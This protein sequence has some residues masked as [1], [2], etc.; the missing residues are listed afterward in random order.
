MTDK[1]YKAQCWLNRNYNEYKK[2]EAERRVLATIEDRLFRGTASYYN[3]GIQ[4]NADASNKRREDTLI[5]YTEQRATLERAVRQLAKK[6]EM[7]RAVIDQLEDPTHQA[8]AIDR[9]IARL[10]WKRIET[11]EHIS[12]ATLFRYHEKMLNEVGDILAKRKRRKN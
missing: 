9:Y 10:P 8:I 2:V 6:T 12:R 4:G 1:A 11:L 7:T 5:E 3:D